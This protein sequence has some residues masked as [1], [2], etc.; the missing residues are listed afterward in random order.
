MATKSA[1]Q[2]LQ[3]AREAKA[4]A[5]SSIPKINPFN[6]FPDYICQD[7]S[8]VKAQIRKKELSSSGGDSFSEDVYPNDFFNVQHPQGIYTDI[9]ILTASNGTSNTQVWK[10]LTEKQNNFFK[11]LKIEDSGG[12][13]KF[14][15][16]LFDR[17]FYNLEELISGTIA[18]SQTSYNIVD[19]KEAEY[20]KEAAKIDD[21]LTKDQEELLFKKRVEFLNKILIPGKKYYKSDGNFYNINCNYTNASSSD[22]KSNAKACVGILS[23]FCKIYNNSSAKIRATLADNETST[24]KYLFSERELNNGL[25][26]IQADSLNISNSLAERYDVDV[27]PSALI[28]YY[29]SFMIFLCTSG[30]I[31][32]LGTTTISEYKQ[33]TSSAL[34]FITNQISQI[35]NYEE[36]LKKGNIASQEENNNLI[37]LIESKN[38][39]QPNIKIRFG[40]TDQNYG[41]DSSTG[42]G[43]NYAENKEY[44][45]MVKV[46]EKGNTKKIAYAER[47]IQ[48]HTII[49]SPYYYFLITGVQSKI[50]KEGLY[51]TLTGFSM[52]SLKFDKFK[53]IQKFAKLKGTPNQILAGLFITFNQKLQTIKN[54]TPIKSPIKL[55]LDSSAYDYINTSY[56]PGVEVEIA[57]GTESC[58]G[59]TNNYK[60]LRSLFNDVC[61]I[62]PRKE[63]VEFITKDST[64]RTITSDAEGNLGEMEQAKA[65][66]LYP[67]SYIIRDNVETIK[68]G[69]TVSSGEIQVIFYYKEPTKFKYC[70]VY[71]W[72]LTRNSIVK[73]LEI[74]NKNEY[75]IKDLRTLLN[76]QAQSIRKWERKGIIPTARKGPNGYR[77]Y[78]RKEFA[79]TLECILDHDWERDIFYN[80]GQIQVLIMLLN[81]EF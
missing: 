64:T 80:A 72:G 16:S 31:K 59:K 37:Q 40:Y 5:A 65:S 58:I 36:S 75:D 3:Q 48:K 81:N 57:L 73:D 51:Y 70:R 49:R 21:S 7:L 27:M 11:D 4:S 62:F 28:D 71:D 68:E 32:V 42:L 1:E 50:A 53:L 38:E 8:Q 15:L 66:D 33:V 23:M 35:V 54:S 78:N 52:S 74:N 60:S 45:T 2:A 19:E 17:E 22:D 76:R 43:A 18:L 26:V 56:D 44:T 25:S 9:S 67:F 6:V 20:S 69:K 63:K 13:K 77:I 61:S 29:H 46:D 34:A 39:I 12:A 79:Y 10:P 14:T 24:G 41:G 47:L 30:L 55:L